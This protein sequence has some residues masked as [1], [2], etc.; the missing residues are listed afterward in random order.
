MPLIYRT[1]STL[2][3]PT[4]R[5][6][7]EYREER[8]QRI[9]E[10]EK[11]VTGRE[12]VVVAHP[13]SLR[14]G[15]AVLLPN[16]VAPWDQNKFVDTLVL[17]DVE[18]VAGEYRHFGNA[19][20]IFEETSIVGEPVGGISGGSPPTVNS[21]TVAR[22]PTPRPSP[23]QP[24]PHNIPR[25]LLQ[26]LGDNPYVV[27]IPATSISYLAEAAMRHLQELER[28]QAQRASTTA[29]R[30]PINPN[31]NSTPTTTPATG[32]NTTP[33]TPT[34]DENTNPDPITTEAPPIA[35]LQEPVSERITED[36]R[37][38]LAAT[39][40]RGPELGGE[41]IE[42]E[43]QPLPRYSFRPRTHRT[44]RLAR[45]DDCGL[46]LVGRRT[47]RVVVYRTDAPSLALRERER[48]ELDKVLNVKP[49]HWLPNEK[50]FVRA[51]ARQLRRATAGGVGYGQ[52]LT[53][54]LLSDQ[55]DAMLVE[56]VD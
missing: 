39:E 38:E 55:E 45:T 37:D 12:P 30:D 21:I 15:H 41:T 32:A 13:P 3:P 44:R 52:P 25:P 17:K 49:A 33:Y 36:E 1:P 34:T 28:Q 35:S 5:A 11:L 6:P 40:Q 2:P 53:A 54:G 7:P 56:E 29:P 8:F 9:L 51:I 31:P 4:V 42:E 23:L 14:T 24:Y 20:L 26:G 27:R 22:P 43:D 18:A 19:V 16:C 50:A 48:G 46:D 10:H 47:R